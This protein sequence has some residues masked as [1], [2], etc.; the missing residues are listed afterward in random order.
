MKAYAD[1]GQMLEDDRGWMAFASNV[2]QDRIRRREAAELRVRWAGAIV[3]LLVV[4]AAAFLTVRYF[5][6]RAGWW[7]TLL[8]LHGVPARAH[9]LIL[10][11]IALFKH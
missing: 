5:G 4:C 3:L 10:H 8:P 1:S 11:G 6:V 2:G 9:A 7:T